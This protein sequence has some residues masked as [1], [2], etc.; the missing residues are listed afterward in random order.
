MQTPST[1]TSFKDSFDSSGTPKAEPAAQPA[2]QGGPLDPI[3]EAP[4]HAEMGA[5]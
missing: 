2:P 3:L 5:E 4:K 1:P